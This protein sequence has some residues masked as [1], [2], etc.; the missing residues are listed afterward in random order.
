MPDEP[1]R[2]AQER[3]GATLEEAGVHWVRLAFFVVGD[4]LAG[5]PVYRLDLPLMF[6]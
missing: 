2:V 6:R 4:E 5:L 3:M 1:N